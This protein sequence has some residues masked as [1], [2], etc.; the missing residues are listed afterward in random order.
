M[1]KPSL[2]PCKL[3]DKYSSSQKHSYQDVSRKQG[4]R[5][6]RER[7]SESSWK[8]LALDSQH[9]VKIERA[10][11]VFARKQARSYLFSS[12]EVYNVHLEI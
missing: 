10:A 7:K 1:L 9:C 8:H 2:D 3:A 12:T 6:R 5:N 4:T 11:Q